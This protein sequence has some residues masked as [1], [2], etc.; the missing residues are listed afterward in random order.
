METTLMG[1]TLMEKWV[2]QF[3]R[4]H[5]MMSWLH[6]LFMRSFFSYHNNHKQVLKEIDL[7]YHKILNQHLKK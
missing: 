4:A 7:Y 2:S 6:L 5:P 3:G 1:T